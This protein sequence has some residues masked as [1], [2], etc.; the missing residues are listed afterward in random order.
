MKPDE[1]IDALFTAA[2]AHTPDTERAEYAFETRLLAHIR[3]ERGGSLFA[4]AWRLSPFLA[5]LAIA[6]AVWCHSYT[7]MEADPTYALD[8]MQN[9]GRSAL[10]AWLAEDER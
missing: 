6:A 3:E 2:R 9:G 1:S 4:W 7:G 10:V 5:V 8:A